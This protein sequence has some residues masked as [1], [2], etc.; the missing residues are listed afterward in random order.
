V[1][2][3]TATISS[4]ACAQRERCFRHLAE[5]RHYLERRDPDDIALGAVFLAH[6]LRRN[7]VRQGHVA[8]RSNIAQREPE[9]VRPRR[10]LQRSESCLVACADRMQ[11]QVTHNQ[12][13]MGMDGAI[14]ERDVCKRLVLLN[15]NRLLVDHNFYNFHRAHFSLSYNPPISRLARNNLLTFNS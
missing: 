12:E 4:S 6:R 13:Q 3:G 14:R 9:A 2:A 15:R 1:S 11:V 7:T 10:I 5:A 8:I